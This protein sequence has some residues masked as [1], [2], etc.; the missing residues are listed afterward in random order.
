VLCIGAIVTSIQL[1]TAKLSVGRDGELC[2]RWR[3][4]PIL[5]ILIAQHWGWRSYTLKLMQH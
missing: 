1:T 3:T 2:R 4:A 5:Q